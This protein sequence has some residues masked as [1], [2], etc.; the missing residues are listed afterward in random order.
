MS[1]QR[2]FF[3][4]LLRCVAAVAVIA[5]H[6][7]AP[8]RDTLGVLPFNQWFT[9]VAVNGASRW[10]VP[11]FILISGALLL[12]DQRPFDLKYYVQRRLGKVLIPF[13]VWSIFY[14]YLSGWSASGFDAD[15]AKDVL[16]NSYHHDT[17]YH[18]G[19]F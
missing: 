1:K 6:V 5:I 8:Y 17:Y 18:L 11:V 14:A 3:F 19:F 10:A 16:A 4:D 15:L 7:L 13:I 2:V 9:A 12:S